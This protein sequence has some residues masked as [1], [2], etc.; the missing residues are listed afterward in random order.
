MTLPLRKRGDVQHP[1][2]GWMSGCVGGRG[3]VRGFNSFFFL[4]LILSDN[5]DK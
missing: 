5:E 3:G 4:P 1:V 2:D